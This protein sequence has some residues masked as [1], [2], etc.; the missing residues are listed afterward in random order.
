MKRLTKKFDLTDSMM[1]IG[2]GL[3]ICYWVLESVLNVFLTNEVDFIQLLLG[4]DINAIW[5]RIMVF[6]LFLIF[7]SHVQYTIN[8]RRQAEEALRISEE[9]HRSI[10]ESIE[11]GY[12]EVD[13]GGNLTFVNDAMQRITNCS[14]DELLGMN[15]RKYTSKPTA[16][17]LLAI[18]RNVY[19]TGRSELISDYEVFLPDGR[20]KT[21]EA[22]V[23]LLRNKSGDPVGFRGVARDVTERKRVDRENKKLEAQLRNARE[24]T[25]L[26]LAKLAEYRDES[27]G[28]HLERIRDYARIIAEELAHRPKYKSYIS[29]QYI[30][31]LYQSSILHDIGK[32][33]TPDAIL[34]KPGKLTKEE[35]ESIKKHA[36][37][38]G[39]ALTSIE[40][41]LEGQSFLSM[42]KEI[43]YF[44]HEKWDGTGYPFGLKH[45]EIPLSA[46]IVA[47]PDVYDALTSR[48]FYK[49]AFPHNEA[50]KIIKG[51]KG[52][53]FDPDV[54]EAFLKH[55][56]R[57]N[58]IR[59]RNRS[60]MQRSP[61]PETA[62]DLAAST[63][64]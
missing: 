1:S 30:E 15:F 40:T 60:T 33:G 41:K 6:C 23:S 5:L 8:S 26:G 51:L 47:L 21:F 32:V 31:D 36:V 62:Y 11:E 28:S 58:F 29:K 38:G 9:K 56:T 12:F 39:D 48:R 57:F 59:M 25:I 22:S 43:A 34:L 37:L 61:D 46:R 20:K 54:V 64:V 18:Y 10:L 52:S 3:A 44:H 16:T 24:A 53:H 4:P 13:L 50:V 17:R 63:T 42:G 7:G 14:K 19:V 35:F 2:I 27:T 45:E 55:E 49:E